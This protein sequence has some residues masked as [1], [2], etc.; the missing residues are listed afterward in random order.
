MKKT[1]ITWYQSVLAAV[2][3]GGVTLPA[4]TTGAVKPP[5]APEAALQIRTQLDRPVLLQQGDRHRVVVEIEI[6]GIDAPAR[7]RPPLN[8]A[9][10]MDRSGSMSGQ[11]LEQARQAASLLVSQ[12]SPN[13]RVSL[14]TYDSEIEV[15]VPSTRMKKKARA[16]TRQISAIVPGGSTALYAGVEAGAE[17]VAEFYDEASLNRVILLSDGLANVGP[18]SNREIVSL[19]QR[20]ADQGISVTTIGL[21][22]DYNEILMT[23]LAEASDA[24]FYHVADVET[25]PEVFE[26]ELGELQSVV[27]RKIVVEVTCPSGV[28]PLRFL[29]RPETLD[30][31]VETVELATVAGKQSRRL[32]LECEVSP[33]AEVS[34]QEIAQV[35]ARFIDARDQEQAEVVAAPVAVK[36]SKEIAEV[37]ASVN[38]AVAADAAVWTNATVVEEALALADEGAIVASREMLA[39]QE[40]VLQ[41]ALD[42]APP[43]QRAELE[44]EIGLNRVA[45]AELDSGAGGVSSESRKQLRAGAFSKRNAR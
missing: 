12:L 5:Q 38:Q 13:D 25:L 40:T 1:T 19:G 33:E 9:V 6:E 45:Q 20:F 30:A 10:V 11:K 39:A 16:I 14:I 2:A 31:Q 28:K 18:K 8:I 26:R 3:L 21:G 27:A 7:E 35:V 15:L 42:A 41:E 17:Q 24:N 34:E 44:A 43:A 22:F 32:F 37:E 23:S 36:F 4:V 29:G